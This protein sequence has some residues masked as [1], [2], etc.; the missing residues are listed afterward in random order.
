VWYLHFKKHR[1]LAL[2]FQSSAGRGI[3]GKQ[4]VLSKG[5]RRT[6][7]V[8]RV[9]H[10]QFGGLFSTT[11]ICEYQKDPL[12]TCVLALVYNSLGG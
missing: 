1:R 11:M 6:R 8:F 12:R 9:I 10:T 2:G 5:S 4:T 7:R 3:S